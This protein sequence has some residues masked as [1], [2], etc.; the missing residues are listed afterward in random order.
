MPTNKI[1]VQYTPE[2][3][4]MIMAAFETEEPQQ[5]APQDSFVSKPQ[6]VE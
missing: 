6:E 4:D 3:Q 1:N 5:E 2:E